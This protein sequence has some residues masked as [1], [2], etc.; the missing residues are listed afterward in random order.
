MVVYLGNKRVGDGTLDSSL[1]NF[2]KGEGGIAIPYGVTEIREGMFA[3]MP[4]LTSVIIPNS[5]TKL[6]FSAFSGCTSLKSITIPDSVTS[7]DDNS[8]SG[9]TNLKE[10]KV[11]KP[12]GSIDGSPWGAENARIIW[13]R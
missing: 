10:I 13:L 7:I 5:V 9:C 3:D 1:M 2:L 4:N 11:D 12:R 8:F 6:S